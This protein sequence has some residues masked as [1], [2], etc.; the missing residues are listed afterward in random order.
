M[1]P[2]GVQLKQRN[3]GELMEQAEVSS[4]KQKGISKTDLACAA[5]IT[6]IFTNLA[7]SYS[8]SLTEEDSSFLLVLLTDANIPAMASIMTVVI[9]WSLSLVRSLL[10]KRHKKIR[11]DDKLAHLDH[12]ILS[13]N[14]EVNKSKLIKLRS[15]LIAK[16]ALETLKD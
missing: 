12:C 7:Q 14:D 2:Y 16:E 10:A 8:E 5:A 6:T 1:T 13:E 15:K 3:E 9:T 4:K 11:F